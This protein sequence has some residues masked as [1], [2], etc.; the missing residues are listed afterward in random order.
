MRVT[1]RLTAK[2]GQVMDVIVLIG[3]VGFLVI[4]RRGTGQD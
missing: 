4:V 2:T 3:G 1:E